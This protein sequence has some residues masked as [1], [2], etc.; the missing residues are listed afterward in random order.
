[1]ELRLGDPMESEMDF[2][3][4]KTVPEIPGR[5][6]TKDKY[7]F[8][9]ALPRI[10]GRSS[11]DDV[12]EGLAALVAAVG[13]HW[14]GRRA[15]AVR[16]LPS[17]FDVRDLPP[18]PD[19][20]E[21]KVA[22]A[23]D[24]NRLEPVWHDFAETPHLLALG[25]SETG[26]TNLLK[27]FIRAI[28]GRWSTDEAQIV[29][30]DP[31][32]RL[33]GLVPA[34]QLAYVMTGEQ[35]KERLLTCAEILKPR[36]PGG[37]IGPERLVRR[38]WWTGPRLFVLLDDYDMVTSYGNMPA[39]PLVPLLAHGGAI[40]LHVVVCRQSTGGMR[41]M[42]EG[43]MKRL[44]DLG[45]PGLLYATNRIEGTF[46]AEAKPLRLPPGRAQLVFRRG[47]STLIQTGLVTADPSDSDGGRP[48]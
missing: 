15:P 21:L 47:G 35:L 46:L 12:G 34:E 40:G 25:D 27:I 14:S 11:S 17:Q 36:I 8:L 1:L 37:D 45:T 10:D 26:R 13:E 19:T 3:K 48:R 44:W 16:L 23:L 31:R 38:D 30:L 39:D 4:A 18:P 33:Q 43:F 42:M 22:Y 24:E 9:T 29:L 20:G 5:G 28:T 2:R 41:A 32:R 6:L 7:H